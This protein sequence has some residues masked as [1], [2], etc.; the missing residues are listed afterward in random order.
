MVVDLEQGRR[1]SATITFIVR[2]QQGHVCE[3]GQVNNI[4]TIHFFNE[5]FRN[6]PSKSYTLSLTE[7]VW[8]FQNS[9]FWDTHYYALLNYTSSKFNKIKN[10]LTPECVLSTELNSSKMSQCAHCPCNA[11]MHLIA[12]SLKRQ[13][14][15]G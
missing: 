7:C 1:V 11:K 10:W 13:Y 4:P 8:E 14:Y 3:I 6:T 5:I 15:A 9:A 12:G 2:V